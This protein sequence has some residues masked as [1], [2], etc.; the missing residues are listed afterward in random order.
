MIQNLSTAWLFCAA[1][2][3]GGFGLGAAKVDAQT[4]YPF[5]ATY[6]AKITNTL[7]DQTDAG[8]ILQTTTTGESANAPY[9]LTN[10]QS[11]NYSSVDPD[12][13]GV[14]YDT[15][16]ATFDLEGF[17]V[18]TAT[19]FGDGSDRVFGTN[20]G[21]LSGDTVSGTIT[22]TGGEGKFIGAT[23]TLN[24]FQTITSSPD[25]SGITIPIEAPA[26]IS[27][28]IQVPQAVPEPKTDATLVGI[29]AIGAS[30]L[31]RRRRPSSTAPAGSYKGGNPCNWR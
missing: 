6:N 7:L 14:T 21:T 9:G 3:L 27:G 10:V 23:G 26:T 15:D 16:P 5:E 1:L 22:L 8:I 28:S 17:P 24:L 18:G 25:S 31:L 30:F 4:T 13:G 11:E 29:G 12:T 2:T 20:R 19:L